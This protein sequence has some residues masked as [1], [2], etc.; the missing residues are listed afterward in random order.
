MISGSSLHFMQ[1]RFPDRVFDVGIAEQHAITFSAG[2]AAGGMRPFCCIYSTFLQRGY[3]QLIHDVALQ[4]LPVIFAV[5]RSGIVGEDGPTHHGVFDIAFLQTIPNL[6]IISPRNENELVR[7]VNTAV[8]YESSPFVIRFPRGRASA[9]VNL[10]YNKILEIGKAECLKQGKNICIISHGTIASECTLAIDKLGNR[11][12][13]AH[14]DFK[15]L[16]PLDIET[17]NLIASR[18]NKIIIA[19][20]GQKIGGLASTIAL[21]MNEA[22]YGGQIRSISIDDTFTTHGSIQ[23][24]FEMSHLNADSIAEVIIELLK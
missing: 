7:A 6:I 1:K 2:L 18:Y 3:D 11:F 5:D 9:K 19:E 4:N 17:I 22:G 15:F 20:E 16:K 10:G 14:Y 24:L 21:L 12:D 8:T 23:E 13:I